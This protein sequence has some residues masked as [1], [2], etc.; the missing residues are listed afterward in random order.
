MSPISSSE[1]GATIR[2]PGREAP[3]VV[4]APAWAPVH[5]APRA[6]RV[7]AA[8]HV[9]ATD[10][11]TIDWD[12]TIAF[13]QHLWSHGFGVAEAMDTAQRGMG[14]T[15]A[16]TRQLIERS[17]AA[18][19]G[20]RIA[21]GV[22]TDQRDDLSSVAA[23]AGA[24]AEQLA[25][26]QD[27][28]AEVIL[29]CSRAL[30][31]TAAGPA[32][33]LA[34]YGELL[35][36]ADRPVILHWLGEAFDPRLAGYWGATDFGAAADTVLALIESAPGKVD[37]VKLSVLDRF[38]EVSLR[39]RLPAGVRLYTGD[40]FN[41]SE[42]ILGD[43]TGHSDALLGVFS[44]IAAPAAEALAALDAGDSDRYTEVMDATVPLGR[45]IFEA[46]TM[47]YK[48]GVA[49]IAWLNGFQPQFVM[50]DKLEQQRPATHFVDVFELA[51]GAGALL[52][53]DLAVAR[54][55]TFLEGGPA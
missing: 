39:R 32:D 45:K 50:L 20:R 5:P 14:L 1:A 12:A 53:P 16:Q 3:T 34:V 8:P 28:G 46:P 21:A 42:L 48:A 13:R 40:D 10:A 24:Y 30:A 41:Y 19:G 33:Y 43:G 38:K 26:V 2:L 25:F 9:V 4:T 44:A 37:G 54:M 51:A 7:Y 36:A 18:A 23:V 27:R 17:T 31:A 35:A 11:G 55:G 52:D 47:Y 15:W 6:R 29:M 22:G 49:F